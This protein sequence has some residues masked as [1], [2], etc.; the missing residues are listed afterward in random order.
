MFNVCYII[1]H[2]APQSEKT[3]S[4]FI[5]DDLF[6]Y[7]EKSTNQDVMSQKHHKTIRYT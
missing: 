6:I 3:V 1:T 2:R 7:L 4:F 5:N